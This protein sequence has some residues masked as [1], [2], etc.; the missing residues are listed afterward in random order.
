VWPLSGGLVGGKFGGID[1]GSRFVLL[2]SAVEFEDAIDVDLG[3]PM[4]DGCGCFLRT[5]LFLV[6]AVTQLTLDLH[7]SLS[8]AGIYQKES[9]KG[10][11]LIDAFFG[12]P[13]HNFGVAWDG[14]GGQMAQ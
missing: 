9:S 4:L 8:T 7:V 1:L 14:L 12:L 2:L 6:L 13:S 5:V 10:G 3:D 11:N